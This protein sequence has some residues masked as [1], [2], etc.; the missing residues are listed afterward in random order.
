[1]EKLAAGG[2]QGGTEEESEVVTQNVEVRKEEPRT[3]STGRFF[4]PLPARQMT[5]M[6]K[7]KMDTGPLYQ[8]R[9]DLQIPTTLYQ[10]WQLKKSHYFINYLQCGVY[11]VHNSRPRGQVINR[12]TAEQCV[13]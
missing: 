4:P 7:G 13:Y 6:R 3:L 9:P 1:M 5:A 8:Q 10:V 2:V 11:I 12:C